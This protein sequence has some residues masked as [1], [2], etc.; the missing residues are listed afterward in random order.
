MKN[1]IIRKTEAKMLEAR[2]KKK[3]QEK[4]DEEDEIDLYDK[5][6]Q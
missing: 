4:D 6:Q 3:D 1:I 2:K 5:V